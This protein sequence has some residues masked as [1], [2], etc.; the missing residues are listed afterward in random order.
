MKK[1]LHSSI[2]SIV[3]L[4]GLAFAV[5]ISLVFVQ[6]H[7]NTVQI[8]SIV[9]Q[10]DERGLGYELVIHEPITNSYSFRAFEQD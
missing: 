8:E 6:R 10:A 5:A 9:E 1:R 2:T 4:T 7:L 3:L